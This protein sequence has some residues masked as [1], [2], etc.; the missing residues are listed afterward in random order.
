[1]SSRARA[2]VT[3]YANV[4]AALVKQAAAAT[5]APVSVAPVPVAPVPVAPVPV[6]PVPVVSST[7]A[8]S[9]TIQQRLTALEKTVRDTEQLVLSVEKM[10]DRLVKLESAF[11][12]MDQINQRVAALE[13]ATA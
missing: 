12:N 1:M 2:S 6:A 11:T 10:Q 7:V 4:K 3:N 13:N 5:V 8:P 9:P